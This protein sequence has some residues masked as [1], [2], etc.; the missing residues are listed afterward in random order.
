MPPRSSV[1][2]SLTRGQALPEIFIS[3]SMSSFKSFFV[4]DFHCQILYQKTE[5]LGSAMFPPAGPVPTLVRSVPGASSKMRLRCGEFF[6]KI[7]SINKGNFWRKWVLICC[8][9][10]GQSSLARGCLPRKTR[11]V[12]WSGKWLTKFSLRSLQSPYDRLGSDGDMID[13]PEGLF[14]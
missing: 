7:K 12:F 6:T 8:G 5:I 11:K 1:D 10:R 4:W 3:L 13:L 2:S 14:S 9:R